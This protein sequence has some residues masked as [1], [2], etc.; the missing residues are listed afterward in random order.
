LSA[1]LVTYLASGGHGVA[2]IPPVAAGLIG[3]SVGFGG[4]SAMRS[5]R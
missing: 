3:A 2:G 4:A 1:M 5:A